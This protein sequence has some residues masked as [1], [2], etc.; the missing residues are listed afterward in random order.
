MGSLAQLSILKGPQK[1]FEPNLLHKI[2]ESNVDNDVSG[3]KTALIFN[4]KLKNDFNK[5][6]VI[7]ILK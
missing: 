1:P 4:G 6:I 2:F 5:L 7:M 3:E